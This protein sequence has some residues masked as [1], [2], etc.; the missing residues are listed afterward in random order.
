MSEAERLTLYLAEGSPVAYIIVLI[1]G[2]LLSFT[3]CILP[4]VPVVIGY[5]G[6]VSKSKW[7]G[8]S[9]S[10]SYVLGLALVYSLLGASCG[11]FGGIFGEVGEIF[12]VRVVFSS[13]IILFGLS[14]LDL[15]SLPTLSFIQ[16]P[17][18]KGIFGAFLIGMVSGLVISPCISPV[19]GTLLL[20]VA[21][22]RNLFFGTT[23]LFVFAIGQGSILILCGTFTGL[24]TN[25]SK[26][27]VWSVRIKKGFGYFMIM[28][29][30]WF[31]I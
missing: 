1:G 24:L 23:L 12:W 20:Y 4:L 10:L 22:K 3:P 29:G 18:R 30:L 19:L 13:L 5:I 21:E 7:Q 16:T 9:L 31:L 8:F 6:G 11:L 25:L 26:I 15:F 17:R 27:G 2:I 28:I 14:M